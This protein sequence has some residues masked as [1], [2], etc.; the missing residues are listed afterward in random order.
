[1]RHSIRGTE[2]GTR[3]MVSCLRVC[4]QESV[5]VCFQAVQDCS[6]MKSMGCSLQD[7]DRLVERDHTILIEQHSM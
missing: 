3:H 2:F 6:I 1:M 7:S 4:S 5:L